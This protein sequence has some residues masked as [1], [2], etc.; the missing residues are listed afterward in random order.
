MMMLGNFTAS[1]AFFLQQ[2]TEHDL[3]LGSIHHLLPERITRRRATAG[4]I[5]LDKHAE[6]K[7]EIERLENFLKRYQI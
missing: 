3:D 1:Y 5:D 6:Q 7:V 4:G 2:R